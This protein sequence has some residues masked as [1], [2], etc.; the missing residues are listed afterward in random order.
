MWCQLQ[1]SSFGAI[2]MAMSFL[3]SSRSPHLL[4][5][6]IQGIHNIAVVSPAPAVESVP[7]EPEFVTQE[8]Y[9]AP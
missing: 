1:E 7:Q 3:P 6:E 4:T 8:P 2:N 9:L 5:C